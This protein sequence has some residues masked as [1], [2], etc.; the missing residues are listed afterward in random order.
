MTMT[1]RSRG[2]RAVAGAVVVA[3]LT[4]GCANSG[5]MDDGREPSTATTT[6]QPSMQS[7]TPAQ[8]PDQALDPGAVADQYLALRLSWDTTRDSSVA[9]AQRRSTHLA[10]GVLAQDDPLP[11]RGEGADWRMVAQRHGRMQIR[12]S[13]A[14]EDQMPDTSTTAQR[15]RVVT[16]TPVDQAGKP[17][18]NP[19]L[20]VYRLTLVATENGWRV[21]DL[22]GSS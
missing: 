2:M 19:T 13:P 10:V 18:G 9:D 21:S 14:S 5:N 17:I 12:V 4:A 3:A 20:T 11:P 16:A 1:S 22:T 7:T 6:Q 8:A 15:T